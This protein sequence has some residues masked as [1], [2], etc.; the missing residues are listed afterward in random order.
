ML[1]TDNELLRNSLNE[2]KKQRFLN[3]Q[4]YARTQYV[5]NQS[6]ESPAPGLSDEIMEHDGSTLYGESNGNN[7][8]GINLATKDIVFHRMKKDSKGRNVVKLGKV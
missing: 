7:L 4:G 2:L 8:A 6:N 3:T 1:L 5:Q